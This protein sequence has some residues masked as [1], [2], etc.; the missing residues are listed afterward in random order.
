[1]TR[2]RIAMG[3]CLA[4]LLL[5]SGALAA[6]ALKSGPQPGDALTPFSPL[7]INGFAAGQKVCQ[8]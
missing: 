5:A 3:A 2:V 8:V 4:T 6:E 7:N 1:M